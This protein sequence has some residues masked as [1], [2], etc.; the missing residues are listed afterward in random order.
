MKSIKKYWKLF[1]GFLLCGLMLNGCED[2]TL[3]SPQVVEE[4]EGGSYGLAVFPSEKDPK[5]N[6]DNPEIF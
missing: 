2:D 4:D 5:I 6:L 3:L 1:F